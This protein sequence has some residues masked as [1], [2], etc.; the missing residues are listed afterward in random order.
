MECYMIHLDSFF[1]AECKFI[2]KIGMDEVV[3]YFF[4]KLIRISLILF[5]L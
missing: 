4:F 5:V 1:G 3:K 2:L